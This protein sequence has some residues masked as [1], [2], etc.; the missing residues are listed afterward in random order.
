MLLPASKIHGHSLSTTSSSIH[1]SSPFSTHVNTGS[2]AAPHTPQAAGTP[3]SLP[4]SIN[5]PKEDDQ[6]LINPAFETH[7]RDLNNWSLGP[8]F[9]GN[10][11][12]LATAVK[13]K[14]GR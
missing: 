4:H 13:I 9:R 14:E 7:L 2:P 5:L 12:Q 6:W 10:F 3:A 1:P 8:S 11:P